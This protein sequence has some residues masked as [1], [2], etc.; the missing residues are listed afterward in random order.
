MK[1]RMLRLP[2][3]IFR[4]MGK[5]KKHAIPVKVV[6]YEVSEESNLIGR[7]RQ[8]DQEALSGLFSRN[9]QPVYRLICLK[10]GNVDDAQELA[11]ETF[12]KAFRALPDYRDVGASFKAYL[13]RI[14]L[15]LVTDY[16][17]KKGRTLQTVDLADYQE[18]AAGTDH[19]P[20]IQA[21]A[22]ETRQA[23][24]G[25]VALLPAEQRQAVELRIIAGLSVQET[26]RIMEKSE[27]A[28]KMLQ[29]RG[30]KNLRRLL[31]EKGI[32]R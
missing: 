25:A 32:V 16:W 7:A 11:Q 31:E 18:P 1:Y 13:S 20:E 21:I 26:A 5:L 8:G 24:T 6:T 12:L 15:N 9:W 30:L 3:M 4:R 28:V 19:Q 2:G 14:A 23:I 27:A 29:Q 22:S 10:T 17:R